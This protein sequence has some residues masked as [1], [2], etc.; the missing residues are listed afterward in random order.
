MLY[1]LSYGGEFKPGERDRDGPRP[2]LCA[3]DGAFCERQANAY[4]STKKPLSHI[5]KL[6]M[7]YGPHEVY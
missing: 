2:I 5:Q 3:G 4:A 6:A 7:M 1:P